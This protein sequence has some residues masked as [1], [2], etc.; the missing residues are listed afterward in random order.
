M[1]KFPLTFHKEE[2]NEHLGVYQKW[3]HG[4]KHRQI[5][6]I[7]SMSAFQEYYEST[8][9]VTAD[10]Q[11]YAEYLYISVMSI[12]KNSDDWFVRIYMDESILHP[13]NPDVG[14]WKEKLT[15]LKQQPLV[16]IVCIKFPRYYLSTNC[17]KE[18]LAVMFRYLTL[19]DPNVSISL[20]RDIDNVYTE[21]HDYFVD[22][23][24]EQGND[25]CF[26][27]NE[28]YKRQQLCGLTTTNTVLENTYY[29]TI[30]SGIWNIR[31]PLNTIFPISIWQKM[32]A[33]IE[34]FTDCTS[35]PEYITYKHYGTRFTYGFDE[36]ALT[37]VALPIFIQLNLT[38]YNIPIKI[39]DVDFF[40]NMFENPLLIKFLRNLSDDTTIQTIK[41]IMIHNYWEMY[42]KNAGLAQ[43]ILCILTNIYFGIITKKSKFYKNE[44]FI[45]NIKNKII[46]NALLMAIG[47][48]TFKNYN[49]YNW[50]PVQ[51]KDSCGSA[52]VSKFLLTNKKITLSEW[53]ADSEL[54]VEAPVVPIPPNYNI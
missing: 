28:H 36:L 20:F 3:I 10:Y 52:I 21:Q 7:Y 30:L 5:E 37:R 51:G 18:L 39:Y 4:E 34:S 38:I 33:Y 54:S 13:Q 41:Q 46:P 11:K 50:Y 26:F 1:D 16:Q 25:I 8:G 47:T 22:K 45:N 35:K 23:W 29:N 14:I 27:M 43:Y 49:R 32:F 15:L 9:F 31:K 6:K 24:L 44:I 2:Y 19:F 53:T 17:H 40:N 12:I 48:F 42:T